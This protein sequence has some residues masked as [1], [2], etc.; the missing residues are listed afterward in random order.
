M[1]ATDPEDDTLSYS[2]ASGTE[3][4]KFFIDPAS[5][6]L[7]VASG[8][9][10]E[11][12]TDPTLDIT[13][14]V[15]DGKAADHSQDD[16]VDATID[17]TINLE[18]VD[19][20]GT[21]SLSMGEPE[22]GTS[23][24]ATL[25]DP[26][27]VN[28]SDW[29]WEKS[30][31]G[32]NGWSAIS[33]ADTDEYTPASS[34]TGMYLR[35]MVD[36]TDGEGSGKSAGGKTTD[37]VKS[38]LV[39][40]SLASLLLS[41]IPFTYSSGTL[42]YNLTAPN[43]RE[44][45]EVMA[46][47]AANS[48]V[49]VEITPTDSMSNQNGHQVDLEVGEI[50]ITVTVSEDQGSGST[51]YSLVV[52]RE[53][54]PQQEDPPPQEDPPQ[55]DPAPEDSVADKCRNDERDGLIANCNVGRFAVVRVE[56]DGSY[57][58]DWS[59]WDEDHPYVTGYDIVL[60][61][62]LYKKYYDDNGEVSDPDLADVYEN[63]EFVNGEWSCTGRVNSNYFESWDGSPTEIQ[64]LASNEDRTEWS[65]SLEK[66]CQH[67]FDEDFV[68]WSGDAAD[69]GN[70]PVYV[71]YRVKVFEMDMYHFRMYEGTQVIGRETVV[72]NGANG[73]DEFQE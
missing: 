22:V 23:I 42:D 25:T 10:L 26:D 32:V 58:I 36:Y 20:P 40:T 59:E 46:T 52:T 62:L 11:F 57:T 72:V 61:E 50:R 21:V 33:G 66:P 27:V 19:E 35:A 41:G 5:G 14:Q 70:V 39:D 1:A 48:G 17:L 3:A 51:S 63:C 16:S 56:L 29:H 30:Q 28:S 44:R 24:T 68:R 7:E 64:E 43:S 2:L 60:N 8:A 55:Q 34:D 9:V 4:D 15:T 31:D 71:A 54:A 37:T 73:F 38:T 49:S 13:L 12:E 67:M 47:P 6:R 53:P 65:S 69:P 45:T 18:N